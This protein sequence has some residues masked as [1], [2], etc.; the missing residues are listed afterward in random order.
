MLVVVL[1]VGRVLVP[2]VNEVDVVV[3]LDCRVTAVGAVGVVGDR[4]F[5]D[6]FVLV[7]VVTVLGV[8]VGPVDVV[9]VVVV[10]NGLMA[11]VIAVS[12]LG[13]GVFRVGFDG[14]HDATF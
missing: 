8:M 13:N 7:V 11:A 2:V 5:R 3:V 4:V 14:C 10:L 9:G 6:G 1:A 12:V